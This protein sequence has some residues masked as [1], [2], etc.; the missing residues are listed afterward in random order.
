M[1][2]RTIARV[3]I[4]CD[5]VGENAAGIAVAA[6]LAASLDAA[7]RGVFVEDEA[8]LNVAAMPFTRHIGAGGES[9]G[10]IDE[11]AVLQQFA[12]HAARL[13]TMMETAARAQSIGW[14]FDVVRGPSTIATLDIGDEDLLV[15]E[16]ETRPFAGALRFASPWLAAALETRHPILLLRGGAQALPDI[17]ALVQTAGAAAAR[18]IATA[19]RLAVGGRTL[20]LLLADGFGQSAALDIV[21]SG[22]PQLAARCHVARIGGSRRAIEQN[23]TAG[24]LL[25]VDAD[26]SINDVAALKEIL[27]M[28]RADILF[29]R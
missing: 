22:S 9:F 1:T 6:R 14:T 12:A 10:S 19:A 7:L 4:A 23:A 17:V 2:E 27:A 16:A 20:T 28:T 5:P 25:I 11:R 18:L 24:R 8:L 29:L 3:V 15:I 21:A 26:P 13:R